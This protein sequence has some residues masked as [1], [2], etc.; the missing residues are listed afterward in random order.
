MNVFMIVALFAAA[1]FSII[2]HEV[3]HGFAALLLGDDTAKRYGRLSLNPLRHI[4]AFGTVLLPLILMWTGS[5]FLFGWAKPVPV[6][7]A[8]L[9]HR[10]RDTV[11]VAS[12]GI[13][14]N[15]ALFLL[16]YVVF[17]LQIL[18]PAGILFVVYFM[19]MN[20]ALILFNILPIP[21]LDGSKIFFGGTDNPRLQKYVAAE[22]QGL[23]VLLAVAVLLPAVGHVFGRNWDILHSY[24]AAVLKLFYLLIGG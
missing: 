1:F 7:F 2:L 14:A 17:S 6:N 3:A 24:F 23:A 16:G 15:F 11:I 5:P 19:M 22:K 8:R 10:R 21:P 18:P 13:A 4:D 12:A 20:I 9:Q